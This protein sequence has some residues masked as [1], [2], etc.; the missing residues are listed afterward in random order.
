MNLAANAIQLTLQANLVRLNSLWIIEDPR[1]LL[2]RNH[3]C[4]SLTSPGFNDL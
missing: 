3:Q 2:A 1:S 4:A